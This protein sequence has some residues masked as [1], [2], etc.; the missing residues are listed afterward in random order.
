MEDKMNQP[1]LFVD[2]KKLE[3]RY[4]GAYLV[5]KFFIRI[6]TDTSRGEIQSYDYNDHSFNEEDQLILQQKHY[7]TLYHEYI[8]YIH[9]VSTMVGIIQFY[10]NVFNRAIFSAF[11]NVPEN[12]TI[13]EVSGENKIKFDKV[14]RTLMATTGGSVYELENR[15]IFR[16]D[17]INDID[18]DAYE[19]SSDTS[20]NIKVP[21][22]TYSYLNQITNEQLIDSIIFG[23]YL[24][25]EGIAHHLDQLVTAQLGKAT[26]NKSAVKPE[27]LLL[28]MVSRYYCPK[29]IERDMLEMATISLCYFNPG[30][31]FIRMLREAA[32]GVYLPG[33]LM[34]I[35]NEAQQHLHSQRD[36][37]KY[38]LNEIKNIFSKRLGLFNAASHLCDVM[39]A[40]YD[41]RLKN[42]VF[43]LDIT[44][45]GHLTKM[46]SIVRPCDMVYELADDD[47]YLRDFAG[48]YLPNQLAND[49]RTLM[50]HV[51]YYQVMTAKVEVHCCPLYTF[52]P[53]QLR[54]NKP[55]QCKTKP[56]L[57][58]ES[59]ET[60]GWCHY[61]LGVAYMKGEDLI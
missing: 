14:K 22:I 21:M 10:L 15:L 32:N 4:A 56:R 13:A 5:N 37:I 24:V 44:Y 55:E 27:Y 58:F 11:V 18:F 6:V 31:R 50:C 33:Y 35:R 2:L 34:E 61:S 9:E 7:P 8:H 1:N 39:S 41:E 59:R 20:E 53:H 43:E 60:F 3:T 23:K 12:S 48:T 51:D 57:S 52:C 54:V 26:M 38:T 46:V 40:A 19:P 28:E 45:S 29:I 42:P 36:N 25:Y 49:L 47:D 16:I 17:D 30:Q